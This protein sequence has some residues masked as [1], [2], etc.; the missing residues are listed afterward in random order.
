L[1]AFC[2]VKLK[3]CDWF[4]NLHVISQSVDVKI[5]REG[6]PIKCLHSETVEAEK[7][8]FYL[9]SIAVATRRYYLLNLSSTGYSDSQEQCQWWGNRPKSAQDAEEINT[10]LIQMYPNHYC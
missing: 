6:S 2:C 10:C 9:Y 1:S 5:L 7:Y 4:K 8:Q 3:A